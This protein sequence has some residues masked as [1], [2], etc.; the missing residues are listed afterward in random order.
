MGIVSVLMVYFDSYQNQDKK[1]RCSYI[2][3][4]IGGSVV[5]LI[6]A[7]YFTQGFNIFSRNTS[8]STSGV[9]VGGGNVSFPDSTMSYFPPQQI[10]TGSPDF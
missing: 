4:F 6:T 10:M 2:K 9:K 5:S 8:G 1:P 7:L 3:V